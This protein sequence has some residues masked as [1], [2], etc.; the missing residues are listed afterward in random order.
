VKGPVQR[1]EFLLKM[2]QRVKNHDY[3]KLDA[4]EADLRSLVMDSP[5]DG[6]ERKS[7][8]LEDLKQLVCLIYKSY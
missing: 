8:D 3:R 1:S 4:F 2:R 6:S 5:K 7:K